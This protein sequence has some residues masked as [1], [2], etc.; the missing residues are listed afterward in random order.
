MLACL[1]NDKL[2]GQL[3]AI[4]VRWVIYSFVITFVVIIF[5][6]AS[7]LYHGLPFPLPLPSLKSCF[8]SNA[9]YWCRLR[10]FQSFIMFTVLGTFFSL[11]TQVSLCDYHT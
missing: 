7:T 9:S 6:I 5:V 4:F 2:R 1:L 8:R 11:F 10:E 3:V